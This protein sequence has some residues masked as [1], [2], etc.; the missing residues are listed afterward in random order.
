MVQLAITLDFNKT[1][2]CDEWEAKLN[3]DIWWTTTFKKMQ[4][5][6]AAKLGSRLDQ[7][8]ILATTVVLMDMGAENKSFFL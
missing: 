4:R 8:T 7:N 5:I 1:N 2:C 6:Q 3:Q